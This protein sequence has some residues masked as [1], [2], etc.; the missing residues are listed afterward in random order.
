MEG[1]LV[2]LPQESA[3]EAHPSQATKSRDEEEEED[4]YL[5]SPSSPPR[6]L[7]PVPQFPEEAMEVDLTKIFVWP[8]PEI[9]PELCELKPLVCAQKQI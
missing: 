4:S 5:A 7:Q 8:S 6:N 3:I 2:P 9:P 1:S